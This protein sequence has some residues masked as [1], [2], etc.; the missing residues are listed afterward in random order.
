MINADSE[1]GQWDLF[2]DI[3]GSVWSVLARIGC[4]GRTL[5]VHLARFRMERVYRCTISKKWNVKIK[6]TVNRGHRSQL[7]VGLK[8]VSHIRSRTSKS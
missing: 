1:L 4:E 8:R 6:A 3:Y 7:P 2:Q 5:L